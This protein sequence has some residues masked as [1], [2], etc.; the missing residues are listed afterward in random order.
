MES[1]I[2]FD[3]LGGRKFVMSII[4]LVAGVLIE[5]YSKNGLSA[6]MVA[7]IGALY[8]TFTGAN[9][10]ITGKSLSSEAATSP[11]DGSKEILAKLEAQQQQLPS[12]LNQ[13]GMELAKQQ[14]QSQIVQ[15]SLLQIQKFLVNIKG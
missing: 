2:F 15:N 8:A 1:G 3:K 5:I 7:L 13:I 11:Q 14:E 10:F 4:C 6:N 9:A 12:I